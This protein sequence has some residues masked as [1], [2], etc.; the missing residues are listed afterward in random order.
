MTAQEFIG[1]LRERGYHVLRM[2]EGPQVIIPYLAPD[3]P[4]AEWLSRDLGCKLVPYKPEAWSNPHRRAY[5]V[6]LNTAAVEF[7]ST[8]VADTR[9]IPYAR[10]MAIWEAAA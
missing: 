2:Q 8:A 9:Q 10:G 7:D 6:R 4:L 5:E 1:G 3:D